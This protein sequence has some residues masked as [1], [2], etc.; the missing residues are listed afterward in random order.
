[1]AGFFKK[2]AG[3]FVYL[4][5]ESQNQTASSQDK[6][7]DDVARE[8]GELIGQLSGPAAQASVAQPSQ[9]AVSPDGKSSAMLMNAEDVFASAA[10][11]D[12]PNSA[13]RLLKIIAGLMMFPREQQI[14][15]VRAMDA[16]DETWS[17]KEVLADARRRQSVLRS[18][19][20]EI[21]TERTQK[22]Q[23]V[24][25]RVEKAQTDGK[26]RLDEIDSQI[27][28]L[29][30]LRQEAVAAATSAVNEFELAKKQTEEAAEKARRGITTVINALS[31]LITFFTG[32]DSK[33][34]E[35]GQAQ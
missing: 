8:T 7:L 13:Q 2:I 22:L 35:R 34:A 1:M 16:A 12:G 27:A 29:Q 24:A 14:L 6:S 26:R 23:A 28:E 10:I 19:L 30:K 18:H 5:E 15:M 3:A 9:P 32:G 33:S 20:Q 17:E 4:D 11:A 25:A 31:D 21:E